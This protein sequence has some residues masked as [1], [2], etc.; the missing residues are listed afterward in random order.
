MIISIRL[1]LLKLE[2][3]FLAWYHDLILRQSNR[4][5]KRCKRIAEKAREIH[6]SAT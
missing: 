5:V 2:M 6:Q 1:A 4:I 3:D